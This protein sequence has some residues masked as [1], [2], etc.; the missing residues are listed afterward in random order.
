[1]FCFLLIFIFLFGL[2]C[3][4]GISTI[5]GYLMP[6]LVNTYILKIGGK[7]DKPNVYNR[8]SSNISYF[9]Q[10]RTSSD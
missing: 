7:M 4:Y 8:F 6:N 3:F 5:L 10:G 1:M 9:I 2:V